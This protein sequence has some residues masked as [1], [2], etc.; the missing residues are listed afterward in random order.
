MHG[1][2]G[3]SHINYLFKYVSIESKLYITH[4]EIGE[5]IKKRGLFRW[6][7][8]IIESKEQLR[9]KGYK[10]N[11]PSYYMPT[12]AIHTAAELHIYFCRVPQLLKI[13]LLSKPNFRK[14]ELSPAEPNI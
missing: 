8:Q 13:C 14:T 5:V 7:D 3:Y 4:R 1:P 10:S 9:K 11:F 2:R 6:K 12:H